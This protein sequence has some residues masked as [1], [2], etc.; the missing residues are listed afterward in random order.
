M[1]LRTDAKS[2]GRTERST[3]LT[4]YY[5]LLGI[6]P[7]YSDLHLLF[8]FL[9]SSKLAIAAGDLEKVIDVRRGFE[10]LR[11]EDTRIAYFRMHRVLVRKEQL[12]FPE[13]KKQEMLQEIRS[14]EAI[15]I[16]GSKPVIDPSMDYSSL[17]F[18]VVADVLLLDLSRM[19]A[20]GS[21]V[22][23]LLVLPVIIVVNGI[24]W[25]TFFI[26]VLLISW[27]VLVIR[28]R[29]SDYVTYPHLHPFNRL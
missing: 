28:V 16:N 15:A 8:R 6:K 2:F 23:I 10:V 9:K 26:S 14:K 27:A 12:R 17:L 18:L 25:L 29:A 11:Y 7:G 20:R 5:G 1:K 13:V 24:S 3:D 22:I 19:F 21:G 4:D